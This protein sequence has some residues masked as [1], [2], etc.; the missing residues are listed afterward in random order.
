[1]GSGT[2]SVYCHIVFVFFA[3]TFIFCSAMSSASF[4]GDY[5]IISVVSVSLFIFVSGS[6]NLELP[7]LRSCCLCGVKLF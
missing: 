6:F 2:E 4:L 1:M 7:L 5:S 3:W